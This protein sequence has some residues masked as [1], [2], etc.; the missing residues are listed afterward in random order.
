MRQ[1]AIITEPG[2]RPTME[3]TYYCL[4]VRGD[5][6]CIF[7]GV[8]DGHG[9]ARAAEYARDHLYKFFSKK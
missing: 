5:G 8:Y 7:A 3:D 6:F 9:G 4:D 2:S 1:I